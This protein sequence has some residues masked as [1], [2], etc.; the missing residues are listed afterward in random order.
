MVENG[1][2]PS[3]PSGRGGEAVHSGWRAGVPL[4]FNCTDRGV[5][6]AAGLAKARTSLVEEGFKM[7]FA[8]WSIL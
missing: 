1:K 3:L 4:T 6:R 8:S 5:V 7:G 2:P